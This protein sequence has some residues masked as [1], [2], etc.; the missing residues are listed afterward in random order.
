MASGKQDAPFDLVAIMTT[1]AMQDA[2]LRAVATAEAACGLPA[3]QD[4]NPELC[5]KIFNDFS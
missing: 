1:E 5:A 3:A 2:I 4:I